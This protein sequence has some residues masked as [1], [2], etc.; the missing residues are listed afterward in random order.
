MKKP[1]R[2]CGVAAGAAAAAFVLAAAPASAAP[3]T[4]WTVGPS[5]VGVSATNSANVVVLIELVEDN[6]IA[7]TCS[8]SSLSGG[9]RSATGNPATVGTVDSFAFGASGAPCSSVLGTVSFA[10]TTP[11]TF[12]ARDH[13]ASTGVTAGHLGDVDIRVTWGAC[14]FRV[15]G[16][17]P[18]TYTNATG[19]LALA[20]TTG[21]LPVV[22][23]TNCGASAPVGASLIVKAGYLLKKT[24]T[25]TVPTIV[26]SHP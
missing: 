16:T 14:V 12:V 13:D 19:R 15:R 2:K 7:V 20:G 23:Q 8:R 11:W 22:S 21:G 24:G 18:A 25:A 26:G 4:V 9:L 5:P 10:P 1:I 17:I 6:G 3:S